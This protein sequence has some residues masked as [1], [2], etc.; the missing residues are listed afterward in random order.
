MTS[1]HMTACS[2]VA[3]LHLP[4]P[5]RLTHI[6]AWLRLHIQHTLARVSGTI[7]LYRR[8]LH[9]GTYTPQSF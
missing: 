1:L 8:L 4:G 6:G 7:L 3:L 2:H 9:F 5:A